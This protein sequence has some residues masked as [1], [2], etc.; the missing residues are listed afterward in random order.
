M[1]WDLKSSFR[2]EFTTSTSIGLIF[3]T[4][5]QEVIDLSLTKIIKLTI[6]KANTKLLMLNAKKNCGSSI[7]R[8]VLVIVMYKYHTSYISISSKVLFL[9]IYLIWYS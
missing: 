8:I 1:S 5:F 4:K 6:I 9:I 7:E 3:K 2:R